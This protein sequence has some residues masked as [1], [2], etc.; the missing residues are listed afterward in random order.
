M[1]GAGMIL[2]TAA[3]MA[4]EQA[5]GK[6]VDKRADIWAFGCVLYEMLTGT[7][8]FAGDDVSE[9]LASVLAREPDW[10]RLPPNLSP[11]LGT[12]IRRC[13]HKNP[14]Q[15]IADAQDIRLALEG[16]F[17]TAIPQAGAPVV[18]PVWRRVALAS[19]A[20]LSRAPSS[21]RRSCGSPRARYRLVSPACRSR[22][23]L[24]PR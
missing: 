14:K 6:T 8:A 22:S 17:E 11:A 20:A 1:T 2:G 7:R 10:A 12:Y 19:A 16:A 5:R 13:L 24:P 4:P 15:R 21:R 9:V 23:R 18:V 3:Y